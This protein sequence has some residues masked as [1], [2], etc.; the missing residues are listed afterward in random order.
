[1]KIPEIVRLARNHGF[2]ISSIAEHK[3]SLEDVFL[4]HVGKKLEGELHE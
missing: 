2:T 4:H 1:M 3:P